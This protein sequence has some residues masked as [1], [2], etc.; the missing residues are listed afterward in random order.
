MTDIAQEEY[1]VKYQAI[2]ENLALLKQDI[3]QLGVDHEGM[4][5]IPN[6]MLPEEYRQYKESQVNDFWNEDYAE[7]Y[8][9]YGG[10]EWDTRQVYGQTLEELNEMYN[11]KHQPTPEEFMKADKAQ[12]VADYAEQFAATGRFE[13]QEPVSADLYKLSLLGLDTDE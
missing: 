7:K 10:P 8:K 4:I 9:T 3:I 1:D 6:S 2:Q 11:K 5:I 12:R 13:W